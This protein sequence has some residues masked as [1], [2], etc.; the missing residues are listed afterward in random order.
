MDVVVP[1][2]G[3]LQPFRLGEPHDLLDAGAHVGLAD[4]AIEVGHEDHG[5]H[6]LDEGPVLGLDVGQRRVGR[7]GIAGCHGE[8]SRENTAARS[9]R[10]VSA[11]RCSMGRLM[12]AHHG[13]LAR[14]ARQ[15]GSVFMDAM[16]K[17]RSAWIAR[18]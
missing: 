17:R 15:L 1:A 16:V 9:R 11:S 7:S 10:M 18:P 6:L 8:P 4:A 13:C 3:I 2:D 12:E 14:R 5:G